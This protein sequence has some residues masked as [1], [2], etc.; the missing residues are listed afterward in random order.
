MGLISSY[1][2]MPLLFA[3]TLTRMRKQANLFALLRRFEPT[4]FVLIWWLLRQGSLDRHG[5]KSYRLNIGQLMTGDARVDE[6][7]LQCQSVSF[8]CAMRRIRGE[9]SLTQESK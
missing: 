4:F 3:F 6:C 9:S 8:G 2:R 1:L 5:V 7:C